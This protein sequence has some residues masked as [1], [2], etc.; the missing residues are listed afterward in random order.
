MLRAA[1]CLLIPSVAIAI[2]ASG[3]EAA[4]LL[5]AAPLWVDEEM[6]ALN[7]RDRPFADL[8]GPLWL[9][10]SA[11]LGWLIVQRAALLALGPAEAALRLLALMFGIATLAAAAWM[12]ERW[13]NRASAALLV[14]LCA[15]GEWLSFFRFEVKHYSADAFW[16]LLLPALAVW[17]LEPREAGEAHWR[18]TRWWAV[19]ALAQWFANGALLVTPGCTLVL[20]VVI[21]RRHGL[22]GGAQFAATGILWLASMAA[23]YALSL[24]YTHHSRYLRTYWANA[25]PPDG[26]GL[27]ETMSW[28]AGRLD[29]LAINPGGSALSLA[30]WGCAIAGFAWSRH[31]VLA[32]LFA[33]V[34]LTAFV[35]AAVRLVPLFERLSL[36]MVPSLY[37][38]IALLFDEGLRHVLGAW[39]ARRWPTL[40]AGAAAAGAALVVS[41]NILATGGRDF[42]LEPRTTNRGMDD[43]SAAKW[44]MD[45]RK[46]GDALV[47]T[48]LGWPALRWYGP[49]PLRT[50]LPG[51]RLPDGAVMYEVSHDRA[52][53]DCTQRMRAALAGHSR[54]IVYTGHPDTPDGFFELL[55]HELA[56][57]GM[58]VERREFPGPGSAAVVDLRLPPAE[59][60]SVLLD[61]N[62]AGTLALKGCVNVGIAR[63]W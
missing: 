50:G 11:P 63:L 12:G 32:V 44:V 26:A 45:R 22:R 13:L 9:G 39:P 43:R 49:I 23:H 40:M 25:V 59:G 5:R 17:A 18:W 21:L 57:F 33:T 6:I 51:G 56:Q 30:F 54:V 34:P 29:L 46:P 52:R 61:P 2:V 37:V 28:V 15:W 7:L 14:L 19:A 31:R 1:R 27:V 20:L 36:W 16:A 3:L 58:V 10:Q 41:V 60:P 8:A 35:L 48:R 4:Q 47:S 62:G 42:D 53:P 38:G 24:Q 55:L